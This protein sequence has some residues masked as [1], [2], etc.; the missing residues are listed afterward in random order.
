MWR[1]GLAPLP[2]WRRKGKKHA[3]KR[4]GSKLTPDSRKKRKVEES[5][6]KSSPGR[7]VR[8]LSD[9]DGNDSSRNVVCLFKGEGEGCLEL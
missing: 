8:L 2:V 3:A 7:R 1:T 6:E 4:Q 5:Q 9:S